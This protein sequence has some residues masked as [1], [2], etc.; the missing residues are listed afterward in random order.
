[1]RGGPFEEYTEKVYPIANIVGCVVGIAMGLCIVALIFQEP[2]AL[3]RP[4]IYRLL[5]A[6]LI[7]GGLANFTIRTIGFLFAPRSVLMSYRGQ[8]ILD[9][10]EVSSIAL[11]RFGLFLMVVLSGGFLFL[12]FTSFYRVFTTG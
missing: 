9:R 1:M 5:I 2:N 10:L 4:R 11:A 6:P 7:V 3:F 8:E 12:M